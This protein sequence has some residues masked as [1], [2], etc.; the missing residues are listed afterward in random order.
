MKKAQVIL[1]LGTALAL[2]AT[3]QAQ[4]AAPAAPAG[5]AA[6]ETGDASAFGDIVVTARKRSESMQK[7]PIAVT[8]VTSDALRTASIRTTQDL[9]RVVPGLTISDQSGALSPFIRGI[10]SI[11]GDPGFESAVSTYVDGVYIG[12]GYAAKVS[13]A[14]IDHVEVLKGPQGTLFGR[15]S[16]GGLINIVT[17]SPQQEF[18]GSVR[19]S[20]SN[21]DQIEGDFYVTGGL[22]E[23]VSASFSASIFDRNRGPG[24]NVFT[25]KDT[26]TGE[27]RTYRAKL[28]FEPTERTV[29]TLAGD[30][31]KLDTL[32]GVD[33][34]L[35]KF[36]GNVAID[37][38]TGPL[39]N[40]YDGI[41]RG[42]LRMRTWGVSAKIEQEFD[43]FDIS[44][45][46]S[47]RWEKDFHQRDL[48]LTPAILADFAW[49][50]TYR[51]FTQDLQINSKASSSIKWVAGLFFLKDKTGYRDGEE[52]RIFGP[53]I[54]ANTAF[55][56]VFNTTSVAAYGEAT[57]PLGAATNVTVGGRY[58]IDTRKIRGHINIYGGLGTVTTYDPSPPIIAVI[59]EAPGKVTYKT[60]TWRVILDHE[61]APN[62]M[63]YA[64]YSRGFKAG[65]VVDTDTTSFYKPEKLDAFEVG[66]KGDISS[67]LR[68]NLSAF[69]YKYDDLQVTFFTT[70]GAKA[71]NVASST[72]YGGELEVNFVPTRDFKIRGS[73][74]YLHARYDK[75][76]GATCVRPNTPPA[77]LAQFVC[78]ASGNRLTRAPSFTATI[79]PSLTVPSSVGDFN[80][81]A[82]YFHSSPYAG[83]VANFL[84]QKT[85]DLLSARISW[86]SESSPISVAVFGSNLTNVKY[87]AFP[88]PAF[89]GYYYSAAMPRTYG[90]EMKIDF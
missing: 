47:Y 13:L 43:N 79:E 80:L 25:G 74:A 64:S 56:N 19:V 18:S 10:G 88:N 45:L 41:A 32:D 82:T 54:G 36:P 62:S 89:S 35:F 39:A 21:F 57:V 73:F 2:H 59:P 24:K 8:S 46:S 81:S 38:R 17:R 22:T 23:K 76:P 5:A 68:A 28:R 51:T 31:R 3:A 42:E 49:E 61:I 85:L 4:T 33:Y 72:I 11:A 34:N 1:M 14:D 15:N 44:S 30:Y 52:F 67:I 40:Y 37:G 65:N 90:I 48:D 50:P 87:W 7:V 71:S 77:G 69:Y 70:A 60:P 20:Y 27:D 58:T 9:S 84:Y 63:V 75:Y 29:I 12:S 78:D 86:K 16:V 26:Y 83:D 53:A 6:D 55:A 66:Y